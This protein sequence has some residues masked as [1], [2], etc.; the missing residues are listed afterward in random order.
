MG[1][2]V[3][4]LEDYLKLGAL[5]LF[6]KDLAGR[7]IVLPIQGQPIS[8]QSVTAEERQP[9]AVSTYLTNPPAMR[10]PRFHLWVEKS[11]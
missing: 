9:T 6:H 3:A 10:G 7:A 5:I 8:H 1:Y 11:P 2:L 4:Y